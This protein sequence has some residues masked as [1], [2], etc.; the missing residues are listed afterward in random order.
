MEVKMTEKDW[1]D[2]YTT[3]DKEKVAI[4]YT[5]GKSQKT[6]GEQIVDFNRSAIYKFGKYSIERIPSEYVWN[7]FTKEFL[8]LWVNDVICNIVSYYNHEKPNDD[9][10]AKVRDLFTRVKGKLTEQQKTR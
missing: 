10:V 5:D 3:L 8:I 7:G 9:K 2:I 1:P 4:Y 6:K